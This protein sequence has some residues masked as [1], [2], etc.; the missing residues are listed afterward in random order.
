MPYVR[1]ARGRRGETQAMQRM[2]RT[3]RTSIL[4]EAVS[5]D[6]MEGWPQVGM[7]VAA[8]RGLSDLGGGNSSRG[9]LFL[10]I[11]ISCT[12]QQWPPS[13]HSSTHLI[14]KPNWKGETK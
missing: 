1:E 3:H 8:G 9:K 10:Q 11:I 13:P 4:F 14:A 6:G 5:N 2:H 7:W 12:Y